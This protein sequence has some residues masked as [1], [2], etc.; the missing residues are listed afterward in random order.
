[1]VKLRRISFLLAIALAASVAAAAFSAP[2]E[3]KKKTADY[4]VVAG[5]VFRENGFAL[6]GAEVTLEVAPE[7]GVAQ[8]KMKKLQAGTSPRGEF[9][10]RVP[11]LPAKYKIVVIARGF[12]TAD[13]VVEIQGPAERADATFTLSTESKH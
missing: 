11:P 1:M 8:K 5:T 2:Q 10:F 13:Q 12:Q 4:S 3:G 9:S 6:A 7:A